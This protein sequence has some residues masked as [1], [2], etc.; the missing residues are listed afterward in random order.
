MNA[1]NNTRNYTRIR[2]KIYFRFFFTVCSIYCTQP[3][4]SDITTGRGEGKKEEGWV[5]IGLKQELH[6]TRSLIY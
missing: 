5:K 2:N 3:M 1:P 6:V 4:R